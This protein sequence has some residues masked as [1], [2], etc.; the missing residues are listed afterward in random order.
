MCLC[1]RERENELVN[2]ETKNTN[3]M[4]QKPYKRTRK[5]IREFRK[6]K[7]KQ[8]LQLSKAKQN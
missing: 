7:S 4:Q 5:K 2:A 8:A 3:S 6:R 1:H